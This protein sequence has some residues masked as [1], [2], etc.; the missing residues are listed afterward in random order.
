MITLTTDHPAASYGLPVLV[1]D[2]EAYGPGDTLPSGDTAAALVVQWGREP[3]RTDDDLRMARRFLKQA[4]L[5]LPPP[6]FAYYTDE[7]I[8]STGY[9]PEAAIEHFIEDVRPDDDDLDRDTMCTAPM[10]PRL[11]EQVER[12]GFDCK[13]DSFAILPDGTLDIAP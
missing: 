4:G 7:G 3:E 9:T 11:A 8:W 1:V 6:G 2:G 13:Y 12:A 10:T 5:T